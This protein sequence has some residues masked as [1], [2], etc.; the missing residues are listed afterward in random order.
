MAVACDPQ[1]RRIVQAY[2]ELA[3]K[4]GFRSVS[5]DDL[6]TYLGMSKKTIYRFFAG[7]EE[8]LREGIRLK[9]A[10]MDEKIAPFLQAGHLSPLE[11]MKKATAVVAESLRFFSGEKVQEIKQGFPECWEMLLRMREERISHYVD[12]FRE[13]IRQGEIRPIQPEI[14]TRIYL[15]LLEELT[16]PDFLLEWGWKW[17]QGV[18]SALSIFLYGVA[19]R[20]G[21][22]D[23]SHD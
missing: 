6:A 4:K 10:E 7:K 12:L 3:E 20:N 23:E 11:R 15:T 14:L 13:G 1:K 9:F 19:T 5:M 17:S 8:V 21:G 16:S 2:L 18:E 22:R